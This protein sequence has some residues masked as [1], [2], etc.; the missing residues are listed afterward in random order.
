MAGPFYAGM[1]QKIVPARDIAALIAIMRALRDPNTGCP[2]DKEQTF[3]SIAPY[4]IEE[5]YEVAGA[6]EDENWPELKD[7]LGDLLLQVVYHARMAEEQK[8]FDFGD[9]VAAITAKMIRRHPHVF[10]PGAAVESA[11]AQTVAWE[12]H[13]KAERAR[14]ASGP[15]ALLDDVPSA[16]PALMRALKLQKRLA[17]VGFDWDSTSKVL[18]KLV[19]EAGEIVDAQKR[20]LPQAKIEEEVGD[21]LFVVVNLARHLKVD[22]EAALRVT[23]AKV[24][25]RF[26]F[27]EKE[28]AARRSSAVDASLDEMEEL[29]QAAKKMV[30]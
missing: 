25:S 22:P 2:W 28:L 14:K 29:W 30:G 6:I 27:V 10:A 8:L 15:A 17:S 19:E 9:V 12:D 13:K 3:V 4:T 7:E 16:L 1:T 18:E 24:V 11:E 23:N 5:A 26:G 21:L 20:G